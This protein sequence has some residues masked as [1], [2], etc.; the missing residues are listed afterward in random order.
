MLSLIVKD[1]I[2][3]D[4]RSRHVCIDSCMYVFHIGVLSGEISTSRKANVSFC[5]LNKSVRTSSTTIY[6]GIK[7]THET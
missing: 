1:V 3:Y 6:I 2:V 4:L 7:I 5:I